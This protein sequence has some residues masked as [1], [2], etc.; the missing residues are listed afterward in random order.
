MPAANPCPKCGRPL[1]PV[2]LGPETAPWLCPDCHLGFFNAELSVVARHLYR[3]RHHD[4]GRG[5][6]ARALREA[7]AKELADRRGA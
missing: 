1:D 3:P 7:V 5:T 2:D 4:W 6:P